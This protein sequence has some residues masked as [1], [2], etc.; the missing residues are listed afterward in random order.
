MSGVEHR[1]G[2]RE[3]RLRRYGLI[4]GCAVMAVAGAML[5]PSG[6]RAATAPTYTVNRVGP[7][8]G[9][10][11]ITADGQGTLYEASLQDALT[12]R[13]TN[14]GLT[15][16]PGATSAYTS[17]GDDCLGTD[18]VNSVYL[19]NLTIVGPSGAAVLQADAYKSVD[20]GDTW[21]HGS[22]PAGG[23]TCGTSCNPFGVDRDWIDAYV[24]PGGSTS[25]AEVVLMYHDFYGPSHIWVNIS[26]DGG[27]TFGAPVDVLANFNPATAGPSNALALADMG[28]STVPSAVKI[29]KGGP[30]PGRIYASWIA[31]DP[32]SA[33]TGCNISQ[34][35]AFHNLF[36][37]WSDDNGA[38]WTPQ[39]AYDAGLF[40]DSSTPFVGFTLDNQGNPYFGFAANNPGYA[41]QTCA[42]PQNPQTPDCEYDMYVVWSADG[43]TTWNRGGGST[44][45]SAATAYKVNSDRGTHWFPAIAAGGPGQVD[46][47]YL[48]TSDIIPTDASGKQHPGGCFSTSGP[49]T[50]KDQWVLHA[51]QSVDLLDSQGQVNATPTWADTQVTASP[52][53]QGDICN[54]GIAC[55]PTANRHLAD[56]ISVAVDPSGCAHIAYAD[57]KTTHEVDSANQSSGCFAVPST[58]VPEARWTPLILAG[59][60]IGAAALGVRRRVRRRVSPA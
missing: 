1:G 19:C 20:K 42:V 45:G 5:S 2:V 56:F 41:P 38:T 26:R 51:G 27:A 28:C 54:L 15:W 59:G 4:A 37:A 39:L 33:A 32:S 40:H 22:G 23:S 21:T 53:H 30:H 13:S 47:A 44:P 43:G 48:E 52:M 55:P 3:G 29:A 50:S 14:G 57:D 60:L 7:Y 9:E 25:T 6:A 11:S 16:T 24:P 31:S 18:Q 12:Y 34:A 36:V 46:V 8:G 49:C 17:T 35:Q 58:V 10:P